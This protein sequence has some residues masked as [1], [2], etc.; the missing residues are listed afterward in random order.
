ME[1]D[2]LFLSQQFDHNS[3]TPF[4]SPDLLAEGM[5]WNDN[6]TA[7][8]GGLHNTLGWVYCMSLAQHNNGQDHDQHE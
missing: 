8:P 3:N 5:F 7:I 1:V 6:S 4:F 2:I